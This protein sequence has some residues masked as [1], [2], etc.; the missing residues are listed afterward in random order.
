[1]YRKY[2]H[3]Y[4]I[5]QVRSWLQSWGFRIAET[6]NFKFGAIFHKTWCISQT[7]SRRK[8]IK[9]RGCGLYTDTGISY[10]LV[11]QCTCI[12]GQEKSLSAKKYQKS[13]LQLT[14]IQAYH[15][16]LLYTRTGNISVMGTTMTHCVWHQ[17]KMHQ[18]ETRSWLV[19]ELN[20]FSDVKNN[21]QEEKHPL[22]FGT[23]NKT[24]RRETRLWLV[25]ELNPLSDVYNNERRNAFYFSL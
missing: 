11:I 1:M 4:S 8:N 3:F 12:H 16:V 13:G 25:L 23:K 9:S 21:E 22:D 24:H 18:R 14:P 7:F 5:C 20:L 10:S 2:F 15:A 17:S 19:E 6:P